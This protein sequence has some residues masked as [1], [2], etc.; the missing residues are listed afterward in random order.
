MQSD[1]TA[2]FNTKLDDTAE[3]SF[4]SWAKQQK[5][6]TGRDYLKDLYDY[7]VRG[8]WK[9]GGSTA[10]N[11]H[12]PDTFKKPNHPTFS[13]ESAYSGGASGLGGK[14]G[15]TEDAPTYAPSKTNIR[16]YG[17]EELKRYFQEVEPGVKLIK[18]KSRAERRY[19]K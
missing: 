18:P 12:G 6:L 10:E 19:G 11:G 9:G 5:D 3:A 16:Q 17:W 15:G 4:Q 8:W 14:W 2:K 7:D 13:E 1:Y